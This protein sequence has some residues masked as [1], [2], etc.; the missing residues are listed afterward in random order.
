VAWGEKVG[1]EENTYGSSIGFDIRN[2]VLAGQHTLDEYRR[3]DL[4]I[5]DPSQRLEQPRPRLSA[6]LVLEVLPSERAVCGGV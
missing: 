3:L 5:V 6:E 1:E 2:G 4:R